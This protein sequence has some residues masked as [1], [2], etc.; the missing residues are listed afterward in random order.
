MLSTNVLPES[1]VRVKTS[2]P[3]SEDPYDERYR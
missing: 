1:D 2:G 3:F